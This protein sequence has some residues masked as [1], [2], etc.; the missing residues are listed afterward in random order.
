MPSTTVYFFPNFFL[1]TDNVIVWLYPVVLG[2]IILFYNK[3]PKD[4]FN[5]IML[6]L[7]IAGIL[8]NF[9]DRIAYGYVIDFLDFIIWPV[10]NLA[11]IYLN[12][13]II[14]MIGMEQSIKNLYDQG[15]ISRE[16]ML[17]VEKE[18]DKLIDNLSGD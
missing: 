6:F 16:E 2:L 1:I 11:D 3:F 9:I 5:Q 18:S 12:V 14:G 7:I 13:G 17:R 8:G 15:I 4:R 10:F